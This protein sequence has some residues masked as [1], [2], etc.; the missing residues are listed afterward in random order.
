MRDNK[1]QQK[2]IEQYNSNFGYSI[3]PE[4]LQKAIDTNGKYH[5]RNVS[6]NSILDAWYL[7]GD[8]VD[9]GM[10]ICQKST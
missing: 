4:D 7:W 2:F 1:L 3:T 9:F 8:G 10:E 6:G 5:A